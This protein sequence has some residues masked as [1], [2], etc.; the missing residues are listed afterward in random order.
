M[1]SAAQ[2]AAP[3]AA[4]IREYR[5][6]VPALAHLTPRQNETLRW[7]C[8]GKTCSEIARILVV[9]ERTVEVHLHAIYTALDVEGTLATCAFIPREPEPHPGRVLSESYSSSRR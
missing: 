1:H 2:A 4:P 9:S 3:A 6:L 5:A 7:L 8:E